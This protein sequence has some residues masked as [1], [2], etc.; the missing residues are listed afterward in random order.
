MVINNT[1]DKDRLKLVL[2]V[3]LVS[4]SRVFFKL[5]NID[6]DA[7]KLKDKDIIHECNFTIFKIKKGDIV[8]YNPSLFTLPLSITNF[9]FKKMYSY[10]FAS[11]QHRKVLL[12]G[13]SRELLNFVKGGTFGY[14]PNSRV[15]FKKNFWFFY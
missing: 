4:T 1:K 2:Q 15:E 11:D 10:T 13:L 8:K 12:R 9:N 6:D 5:V 3:T 14:N 7:K